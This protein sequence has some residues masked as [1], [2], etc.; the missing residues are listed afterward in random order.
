[1]V[2]RTTSSL[3]LN[4][5]L[6]FGKRRGQREGPAYKRAQEASSWLESERW[7]FNTTQE[8]SPKSWDW[9]IIPGVWVSLNSSSLLLAT[10]WHLTQWFKIRA[11]KN[12]KTVCLFVCLWW[13]WVLTQLLYILSTFGGDLDYF[14]LPS[15]KMIF[16]SHLVLS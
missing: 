5:Y 16:H 15:S 11:E 14:L 1:M 2:E 4:L 6:K 8:S 9:G 7:I 3:F 13:V 10:I 12:G